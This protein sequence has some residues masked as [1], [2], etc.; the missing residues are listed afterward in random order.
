MYPD[1]GIVCTDRNS[2]RL[3]TGPYDSNTLTH[4]FSGTN[5]APRELLLGPVTVTILSITA[6]VNFFLKYNWYTTYIPYFY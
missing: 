6:Q 5:N 1:I 4:Q 3:S 2:D